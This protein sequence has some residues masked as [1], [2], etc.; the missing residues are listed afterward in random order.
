ML[1]GKR[2]RTI[3][4]LLIVE[5]EPL[6][7][8]DNEHFLTDKGFEVVATVDTVADALAAIGTHAIDLILA[9]VNLSDGNGIDVAHAARAKGIPVLFVT[10]ACP[11][12]AQ[13]VSLGCLAKPYAQ[14]DLIDALD[15]LDASI[16]GKPPKRLP[17]GL[18]LYPRP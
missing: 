10:G 13:A 8:F 4:R 2:A 9:D 18:S 1:F 6:V 16:A 3:H 11:I 7:A 12:E 5:D 15:A 14:R 17:R